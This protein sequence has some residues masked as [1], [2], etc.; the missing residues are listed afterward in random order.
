RRI[1]SLVLRQGLSLAAVG[2]LLGIPSAIGFAALLSHLLYGLSPAD[3][4]TLCAIALLLS[5]CTLAASLAPALH[6][7]STNPIRS[8]RTG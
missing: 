1:L 6:A 2:F 8:L 4:F 3:P 5:L 7:A